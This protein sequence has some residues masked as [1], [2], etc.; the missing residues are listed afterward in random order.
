MADSGLLERARFDCLSFCIEPLRH[1]RQEAHDGSSI[2]TQL[3]PPPPPQRDQRVAGGLAVR[4]RTLLGRT[5]RHS[6]LCHATPSGDAVPVG[7]PRFANTGSTGGHEALAQLV[8]HRDIPRLLP[9]RFRRASTSLIQVLD[10]HG[11]ETR[12]FKSRP[13]QTGQSTQWVKGPPKRMSR[14]NPDADAPPRGA[15]AKGSHRQRGLWSGGYRP[16][17]RRDAVAAPRRPRLPQASPTSER[18]ANSRA[19]C[20]SA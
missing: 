15:P 2:G 5:R 10:G 16:A 14:G 3:T 1:Q 8:E 9:V 19:A 18:A 17:N 4:P 11:R 12:G 7:V 20:G 6:F 13:E